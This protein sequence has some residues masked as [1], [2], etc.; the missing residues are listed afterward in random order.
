MK[1][2]LSFASLVLC[3][4]IGS[5]TRPSL[6]DSL[7]GEASPPDSYA[8]MLKKGW[9]PVAEGVLQRDRGD[10]TVETFAFGS[11]GFTWAAQHLAG[12]LE[13]MEKEYAKYPSRKLARAIAK[14]KVQIAQV[15]QT[16]QPAEKSGELESAYGKSDPPCQI[17]YGGSA[18]AFPI[19]GS[20]A[21]AKSDAYFHNTCGLLGDT[22]AYAFSRADTSTQTT[23]D[24]RINGAWQDSAAVANST[25][26]TDCYSEASAHVVSGSLN[27]FYSVVAVPN[28]TCGP[29]VPPMSVTITGS[30]QAT[31]SGYNCTTLQWSASVSGGAAPYTY[32]WYYNGFYVGSSSGYSETFCGNNVAGTQPISLSV[33]VSDS[34]GQSAS[35]THAATLK[36][37]GTTAPLPPPCGGKCSPPVSPLF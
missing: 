5:G 21:G 9:K 13:R 23:Y 12:Q 18:S 8:Q 24:P 28:Y 36:Y 30:T 1:Q 29:P 16:H 27:I 35:D 4:L 19:S 2:K 33:T 3:L 6:A 26:G 17:S 37:T 22:N 32:S 10:G 25:G 20:G 11:E 31:I 15:E 7:E 34:L 14:Q